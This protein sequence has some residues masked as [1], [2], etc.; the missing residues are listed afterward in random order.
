MK[1]KITNVIS[2][3]LSGLLYAQQQQ[4]TKA[5]VQAADAELTVVY[6]EVMS[7][8][9]PQDKDKI[10]Q[11][12]REWIKQRD[13]AVLANPGREDEILKVLTLQQVQNLRALI[14]NQNQK[15][16][17]PKIQLQKVSPESIGLA[18][19]ELS[20]LFKEILVKLPLQDWTQF[21]KNQDDWNTECESVLNEKY[22]IN[23]RYNKVL[24]RIQD[25]EK[26]VNFKSKTDW[27][28]RTYSELISNFN[29]DER[30]DIRE[31]QLKWKSEIDA[32]LSKYKDKNDL[33]NKNDYQDSRIEY[34]QFKTWEKNWIDNLCKSIPA[35]KDIPGNNDVEI[36][37]PAS[38]SKFRDAILDKKR[39][40]II[41]ADNKS[42]MNWKHQGYLRAWDMRTGSLLRQITLPFG[43][44]SLAYSKNYGTLIAFMGPI[45]RSGKDPAPFTYFGCSTG[46]LTHGRNIEINQNS[47]DKIETGFFA[48]WDDEQYR[49][50]KPQNPLARD[51]NVELL[52]DGKLVDKTTGI[53]IC[54]IGSNIIKPEMISVS[55]DGKFLG[56]KS[57]NSIWRISWQQG[58]IESMPFSL[59]LTEKDDENVYPFID[60]QV[61]NDGSIN[62]SIFVPKDEK[63]DRYG[64]GNLYNLIVRGNKIQ[65]SI[66]TQKLNDCWEAGHHIKL[67]DTE[68]DFFRIDGAHPSPDKP[69]LVL[70]CDKTQ[71]DR[72]DSYAMTLKSTVPPIQSSKAIQVD[73]LHAPRVCATVSP[74]GKSLFVGLSFSGASMGNYAGEI[75]E[76]DPVTLTRK[77]I[78]AVGGDSTNAKVGEPFNPTGINFISVQNNNDLLLGG[79][80]G[81][82]SLINKSGILKSKI[83]ISGNRYGDERV[84]CGQGGGIIYRTNEN[85]GVSMVQVDEMGQLYES[86]R[87]F[88][89]D[90]GGWCV[91]NP[92]T[93]QFVANGACAKNIFFKKGDKTFPFEQFD[94]QLNRPDIILKSLGAPDELVETAMSLRQ[95][96]LR[97]MDV[98]EEMLKPGFHLPEIELDS[99]VP[100]NT[101]HDILGLKLKATDSKYALERLHVYVNNVPMNGRDGES[102][103]ELKTQNLEKT[104]PV[105]LG[106][107]R[108]KIQVSVLNAAGAESLYAN[109]EVV[110]T[111][112]RPKPTLYLV[113]MGVSKYANQ[114]W[115]L[116]YAAKDAEDI[117]NKLK[118]KSQNIYADVKEL[119]L[120]DG[121][122]TR[123]SIENV[124]TFL[125]NATI[126]DSVI[127]FMAGHGILDEKYDYYFGTSDIDFN[128]PAE[129]GLSFDTI[130]DLLIAVPSLN[131]VLLMDTCH[132]GELDQE[133]KTLLAKADGTGVSVA[134][135]D[136]SGVKARSVGTRGMAL[137]G[138]AGGMERSK[139]YEKMQDMFLDLRRGSGATVLTSSAGAEYAFES[140]E[141]SNGLFTYSVLEALDGAKGV[142][143]KDGV[144]HVSE[145]INYVKKRV[146]ELTKG[147]QT[148]NTRRMNVECNFPLTMISRTDLTP[149]G[150]GRPLRL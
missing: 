117:A 72:G 55:E 105:K 149:M 129:K 80:Y 78:V 43:I 79:L 139:W 42:L 59:N 12:E 74:D 48:K 75:W 63:E 124:R 92:Q 76:C 62:G 23:I 54:K 103:R 86:G 61:F 96:R 47:L 147:K 27:L 87:L 7:K 34:L 1:T 64:K 2:L 37:I 98:T 93:N 25:F 21:K 83:H 95:K 109:A 69:G 56:I 39:G 123:Q 136:N 53:I 71:S 68:V 128:K 119:L 94:L 81:D 137:K 106:L 20:R 46:I 142:A 66:D 91:V 35:L 49:M 14:N 140:S 101:D 17:D 6:K 120:T 138:F 41:T 132:A 13:A 65:I 107:G 90:G 146:N 8:L 115:N 33:E 58:R 131:K 16:I 57:K 114:D 73:G 4:V 116:K 113:S 29:D 67:D 52:D 3:L 19:A 130:D 40:I 28:D 11:N 126:D 85:N 88:L 77:K 141:Q 51:E 97:R 100:L 10:R 135:S 82:I 125:A 122:V 99:D 44:T 134:V 15:T 133:E 18:D 50:S 89:F 84:I 148:P 24:L 104:I 144:I 32:K 70:E 108:N 118:A 45:S 150:G 112:K 9:S 110:C 60:C 127:I 36:C 121:A 38:I 22:G 145:V 5:E 102:L 31:D 111:A 143:D 30:K 26:K